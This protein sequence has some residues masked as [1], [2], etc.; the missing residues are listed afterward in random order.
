METPENF[1][2]AEIKD[3]LNHIL[4][5]PAFKNSRV[6]SGFLKFVINETLAGREQEIK[7]YNIGI[8]VLCR[9]QDFNPQ[10]D[11]IVRIHAGRLR[12]VLKEYYHERGSNYLVRIEIPKGGYIPVFLSPG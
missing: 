8:Q 3:Q 7:E 10:I 5:S 1:T 2:E 9:N 6:L 12:R 4:S 11:S